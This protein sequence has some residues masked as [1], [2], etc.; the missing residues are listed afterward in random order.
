MKTILTFSLTLLSISMLTNEECVFQDDPENV[1]S[2]QLEGSWGL[3][4]EL[5]QVLVPSFADSIDLKEI[6]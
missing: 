3:N 1:V 6:K 2:T 5:T 4:Q